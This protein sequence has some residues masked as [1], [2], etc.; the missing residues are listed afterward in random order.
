[1]GMPSRKSTDS[2]RRCSSSSV[3]FSLK[4]G[5][6]IDRRGPLDTLRD[7]TETPAHR[8]REIMTNETNALA[9]EQRP[10]LHAAEERD[11]FE[12]AFDQRRR[13]LAQSGIDVAGMDHELGDAGADAAQQPAHRASVEDAGVDPADEVRHAQT[14]LRGDVIIAARPRPQRG[15]GPRLP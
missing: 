11:F 5:T 4:S 14:Q 1:E 6:T 10:R 3:F 8:W 2:S 7:M 9:G 13:Q 15:V 12:A